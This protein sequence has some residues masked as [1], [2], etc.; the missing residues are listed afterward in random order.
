MVTVN[1]CLFSADK[2]SRDIC[3]A[4]T[5]M[6]GTDVKKIPGFDENLVAKI[7]QYAGNFAFSLKGGNIT[8]STRDFMV[9]GLKVH[10]R[11]F[12]EALASRDLI[13][14]N[15]A[16]F[17]VSFVVFKTISDASGVEIKP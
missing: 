4:A 6:L 13:A 16:H 2:L 9:G 5:M 10:I 11:S 1:T 12:V 3:G 15:K 17:G 8:G 7:V 14:L